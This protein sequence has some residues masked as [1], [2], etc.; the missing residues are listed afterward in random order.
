MNA[1]NLERLVTVSAVCVFVLLGLTCFTIL[2]VR[3]EV[4]NIGAVISKLTV[5]PV[6]ASLAFVNDDEIRHL[7]GRLVVDQKNNTMYFRALTLAKPPSEERFRVPIAGGM[8]NIIAAVQSTTAAMG[9]NY[10]PLSIVP[11]I[12]VYEGKL[13]L[14]GTIVTIAFPPQKQ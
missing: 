4:R 7:D 11:E 5:A 12:G 14:M 2:Q 13:A 8:S 9:P 1:K 3:D 10:T 6:P